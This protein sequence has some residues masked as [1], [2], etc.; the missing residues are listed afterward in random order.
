LISPVTFFLQTDVNQP[1]W[2]CNVASTQKHQPSSCRRR[3]PISKHTNVLGT[4]KK[5]VHGSRR[6]SKPRTTVLARSG[7]NLLLC[8]GMLSLY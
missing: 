6:G 8:Y 4:N 7:K 5:F 1:T 3:G 2:Q